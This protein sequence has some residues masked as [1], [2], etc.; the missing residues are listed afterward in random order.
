MFLLQVSMA[1][2]EKKGE[3]AFSLCFL[4][5]GTLDFSISEQTFFGGGV[6]TYQLMQNEL[7]LMC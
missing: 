6:A 3:Q 4:C 2:K 7:R 1:D 5:P